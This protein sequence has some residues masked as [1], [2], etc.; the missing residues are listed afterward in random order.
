MSLIEGITVTE[1]IAEWGIVEIEGMGK[2]WILGSQGWDGVAT[3]S[4]FTALLE[5]PFSYD[6][7]I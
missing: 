4:V 6:V 7:R 2:M 5:L 3:L 1:G